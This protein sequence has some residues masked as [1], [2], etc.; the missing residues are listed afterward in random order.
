MKMRIT[1]P[2]LGKIDSVGKISKIKRSGDYV[3]AS[4]AL[5]TDQTM[6]WDTNIALDHKD[7]TRLLWLFAKSKLPLFLLTGVRNRNNPRP[8]PKRW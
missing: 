1:S 8:L 4:V 5:D 6:D 2:D 7:L 3:I